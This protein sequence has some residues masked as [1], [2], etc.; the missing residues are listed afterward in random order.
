M[1]FRWSRLT[2]KTTGGI[3]FMHVPCF[4]L[5]LEYFS[6]WTIGTRLKIRMQVKL[7]HLFIILFTG[8]YSYVSSGIR[9]TWVSAGG[10]SLLNLPY[11]L[12]LIRTFLL[13]WFFYL[14]DCSCVPTGIRW[15]SFCGWS[16]TPAR[17]IFSTQIINYFWSEQW[18]HN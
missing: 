1:A 13:Y 5:K 10:I 12:R 3:S 17:S 9:W 18:E 15:L 2:S 4:R 6:I 8:E 11:F 16:F 14:L 7:E